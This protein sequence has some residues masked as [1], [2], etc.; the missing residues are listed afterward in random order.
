MLLNFSSSHS[1][2]SNELDVAMVG[3]KVDLT[4]E[5]ENLGDSA[6]IIRDLESGDHPFCQVHNIF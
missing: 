3:P 6:D 1:W 2:L 5:H 4:F